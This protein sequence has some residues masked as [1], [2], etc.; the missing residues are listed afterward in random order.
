M[1]L[2]E[3]GRRRASVTTALPLL[4]LGVV[5]VGGVGAEQDDEFGDHLGVLDVGWQA[6]GGAGAAGK[7]AG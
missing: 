5:G 2:R 1:A 3:G 6:L 7:G 4:G